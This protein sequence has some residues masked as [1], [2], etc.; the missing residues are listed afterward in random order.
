[1][2]PDDA[3]ARLAD[4]LTEACERAGEGVAFA[5]AL[6][7]FAVL[8]AL[9]VPVVIVRKVRRRLKPKPEPVKAPPPDEL[10]ELCSAH[11]LLKPCRECDRK[12]CDLC[13]HLDF[14]EDDETAEANLDVLCERCGDE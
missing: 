14:G 7:V 11:R 6:P 12:V 5:I 3:L 9:A 2:R 8:L 1:M 13:V 4:R 10:C